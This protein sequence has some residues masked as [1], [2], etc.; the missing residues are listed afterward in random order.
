MRVESCG[1]GEGGDLVEVKVLVR[2]R[3][4]VFGATVFGNKTRTERRESVL[5]S[6][7]KRDFGVDNRRMV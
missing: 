6:L 4:E 7:A 5:E 2:V 3:V 1:E